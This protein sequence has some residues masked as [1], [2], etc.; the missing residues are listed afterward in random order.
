MRVSVWVKE[1]SVT[2][3]EGNAESGGGHVGAGH[4]LQLLKK[5]VRRIRNRHSK[6]VMNMVKIRDELAL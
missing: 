6:R 2:H 5:G 1:S 4:H 3:D